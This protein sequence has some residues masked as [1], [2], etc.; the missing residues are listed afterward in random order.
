MNFKYECVEYADQFKRI[1]TVIINN[2]SRNIPNHKIALFA[3]GAL[4]GSLLTFFSYERY[5]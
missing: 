3:L 1:Y 2:N 5:Y 4:P